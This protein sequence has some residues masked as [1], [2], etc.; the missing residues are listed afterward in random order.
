MK[1]LEEEQ[2]TPVTQQ[3]LAVDTIYRHRAHIVPLEHK[4]QRRIMWIEQ[5]LRIEC[6]E[7]DDLETLRAPNTQS[8]AQEM[9]RA[10]L[11]G[12]IELLLDNPCI[13]VP[14]KNSL[15]KSCRSPRRTLMTR[16]VSF[17]PC[18]SFLNVGLF[19]PR[20]FCSIGSSVLIVVDSALALTTHT[21]MRPRHMP[22]LKNDVCDETRFARLS[23]AMGSRGSS[24]SSGN[25][26]TVRSERTEVHMR[27]ESRGEGRKGGRNTP[28]KTTSS[29]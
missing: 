16:K 15:G 23:P 13:S 10:R 25:V 6:L 26:M 11:H 18:K 27:D 2:L 17:P 12:Y 22:A 29:P 28:D 14:P 20:K 21:S 4:V 9:Y 5:S 7:I 3:E 19:F 8:R 1:A 24:A